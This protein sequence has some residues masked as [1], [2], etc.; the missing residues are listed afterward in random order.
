MFDEDE[1]FPRVPRSP[2]DH[3]TMTLVMHE[4]MIYKP[5]QYYMSLTT[6]SCA[7]LRLH[8]QARQ[9]TLSTF[10]CDISANASG[11]HSS[12]SLRDK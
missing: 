9:G 12:S 8:M 10:M 2:S 6:D 5:L 4:N 3:F 11:F 1:E 7:I